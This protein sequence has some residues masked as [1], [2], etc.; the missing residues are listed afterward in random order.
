MIVLPNS[1][2]GSFGPATNLLLPYQSFGPNSEVFIGDFN[3]D[4]VPDIVGGLGLSS[5]LFLNRD[6]E[7]LDAAE[8]H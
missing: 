8:H 3:G 2:G 7:A 5:P 4:G 6:T 1:G